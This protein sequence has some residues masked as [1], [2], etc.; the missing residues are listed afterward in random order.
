MSNPAHDDAVALIPARGGSKGIPRKNLARIRGR[1]LLEYAIRAAQASGVVARAVVSS[2]DDEILDEARRHGA[3]ALKRPPEIA[4]DTASSDSVIEHFINAAQPRFAASQPIVLLQPTSPLRTGAHVEQA[5]KLW[6]ESRARA[7]VSVF[8]PEHHPAKSFRL[9]ERGL[10]CG[11]FGADAPFTPRQSLPRAFQPN[12]AVYVFSAAEFLTGRRIPRDLLV[13]LVM[14]SAESLDIDCVA[15]L[16]RAEIYL[17]GISQ[18][19]V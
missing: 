11:L 15:D 12:G 17:Q 7:V 9:D 10:L 18:C 5:V 1:T 8:E 13:P 6:R 19:P 14:S 3:E 4:S 2:D 16:S